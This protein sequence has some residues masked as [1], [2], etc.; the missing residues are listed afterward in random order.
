MGYRRLVRG[1]ATIRIGPDVTR[2]GEGRI[3]RPQA[4][5]W[6]FAP[7]NSHLESS[8]PRSGPVFTSAAAGDASA[9]EISRWG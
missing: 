2:A 5:G 9:R 6:N 3:A 4:T 1:I 7:E 8:I